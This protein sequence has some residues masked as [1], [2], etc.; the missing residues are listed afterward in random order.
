M[1]GIIVD[2]IADL[3]ERFVFLKNRSH[4]R[5]IALWIIQTHF[6]KD[7]RY[8]GYIFIHSPEPGCGKTRLMELAREL[9]ANPTGIEVS[10]T[11]AVLFRTAEGKTQFF[12]EVDTWLNGNE[13]RSILNS[14]FQEGATVTRMEEVEK[15]RVPSVFNVYGPR[16]LA[17]IGSTILHQTTRDRTFVIQMVR[18]T[19][20]ERREKF[21]M[22]KIGPELAALKKEIVEWIE[23]F[24]PGVLVSYE[25]SE[26]ELPYL[27]SLRDRTQDIAEPLAA[28][29]E[30]AYIDAPEDIRDERRLELLEAIS[31]TREELVDSLGDHKIVSELKRL[32]SSDGRLIGTAS[33]LASKCQIDPHPNEYDIAF[34]LRR[35]GFKNRNIRVGKSVQ[36]RYD[37]SREDL[38][39]I[40]SRFGTG[41]SAFLE[42]NQV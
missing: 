20:A 32:A 36:R 7:F 25:R 8:T 1:N 27:D 34:V 6:Y 9:A 33:E 18:A 13:L 42:A 29:L 24:K 31:L 39:D 40:C 12:D 11:P 30:W 35:Y 4:Y 37:L 14:G 22:R 2:K 3:I 41:K 26:T 16:M 19:R 21:R 15:R 38:T 5:L 28:I 17:G 23:E 10:P